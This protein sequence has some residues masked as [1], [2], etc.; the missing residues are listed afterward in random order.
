[1][2]MLQT[3]DLQRM[4]CLHDEKGVPTRFLKRLVVDISRIGCPD[5]FF[6]TRYYKLARL[7]RLK[8]GESRR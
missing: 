8:D 4:E 1:M 5:K 2:S 3:P 6:D 7:D